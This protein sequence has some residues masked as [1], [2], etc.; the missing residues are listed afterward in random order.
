[1]AETKAPT[2]EPAPEQGPDQGGGIFKMIII[3]TIQGQIIGR[4][5]WSFA[6]KTLAL[7]VLLVGL[8]YYD[9]D[10]YLK[11]KQETH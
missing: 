7:T 9:L 8:V 3:Q 6:K 1:M 5:K 10:N 2:G 11:S 4:K